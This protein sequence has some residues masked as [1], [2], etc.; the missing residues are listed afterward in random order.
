[1]EAVDFYWS[2]IDFVKFTRNDEVVVFMDKA[3]GIMQ[4]VDTSFAILD[5][6]I[7]ELENR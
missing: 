7:S 4:E 2:L 1:M 5:R 3:I 6:V